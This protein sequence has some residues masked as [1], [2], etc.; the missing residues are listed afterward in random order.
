[1]SKLAEELTE[2]NEELA[3][4]LRHVEEMLRVQAAV[5]ALFAKTGEEAESKQRTVRIALG[6]E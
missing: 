3:A 4:R 5:L 1:M 6:L 2:K